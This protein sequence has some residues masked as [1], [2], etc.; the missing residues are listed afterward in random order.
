MGALV[1]AQKQEIDSM[2]EHDPEWSAKSDEFETTCQLRHEKFLVLLPLLDELV[3]A[4][5][6][7]NPA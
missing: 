7:A 6:A 3:E 5:R 1:R 2:E 4:K